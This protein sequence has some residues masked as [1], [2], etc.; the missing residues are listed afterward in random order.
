MPYVSGEQGEIIKKLMDESNIQFDNHEYKMSI[1]LLEQAWDELLDPKFIYDESY[2]IVWGILDIC[3]LIND[4]D[5]ANKW[6]D[7]IFLCDPERPDTGEREYWAGKVA[8][9]TRNFEKAK[10]YLASA[11]K[12]SRG[13]CF[14]N[15]DGKY[16]RFLKQE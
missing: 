13:R 2:L 15:K 11:N 1:Q 6:V 16:L 12:K 10:E 3:V 8:Y 4:M 14:G 7:K 5:K 9:E